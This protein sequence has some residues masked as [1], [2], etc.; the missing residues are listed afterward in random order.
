MG[1]KNIKIPK[2]SIKCYIDNIIYTSYSF[3][4]YTWWERFLLIIAVIVLTYVPV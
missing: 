1:H 4:V 2:Q 3:T